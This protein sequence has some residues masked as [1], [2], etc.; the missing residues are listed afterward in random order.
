MVVC[1]FDLNITKKAEVLGLRF[2]KQTILYDSF[3]FNNILFFLF[4]FGGILFLFGFLF[5]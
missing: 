1:F 3:L 5:G 4:L 2:S